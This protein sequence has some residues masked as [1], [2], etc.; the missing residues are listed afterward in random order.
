MSK[1]KSNDLSKKIQ[2][3]DEK[4]EKTLGELD[5]KLFESEM[6]TNMISDSLDR[7]G[8]SV[9]S[10]EVDK[11]IEE[12]QSEVNLDNKYAELGNRKDREI[13][14]RLKALKDTRPTEETLKN[15]A[16][17]PTVEGAIPTVDDLRETLKK[18]KEDEKKILQS[19]KPIG[20]VAPR[21]RNNNL[22]ANSRRVQ[23]QKPSKPPEIN[24]NNRRYDIPKENAILDDIKP[25]KSWFA[26][27]I[28]K[29]VDIVKELL[30][31]SQNQDTPSPKQQNLQEFKQRRQEILAPVI[32]AQKKV[33][34]LKEE[35]KVSREVS[36]AKR[37]RHSLAKHD[38]HKPLRS[39]TSSITSP[40]STPPVKPLVNKHDR[41][42]S[43][44]R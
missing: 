10:S 41:G 40:P 17:T 29:V 13:E 44:D 2:N 27:I 43:N 1:K 21:P 9:S 5:K 22:A 23:E 16:P 4:F 37:L 11:L 15:S 36:K 39:S 6:V 38:N 24:N 8:G 33:K 31:N 42:N 14:A 25:G 7:M 26:K 19:T 18:L 34:L 30:S 35:Q 12:M 3:I 32:Q 28:D 20:K